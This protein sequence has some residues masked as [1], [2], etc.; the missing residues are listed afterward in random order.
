[1]PSGKKRKDIKFLLTREKKGVE[2]IDIKK[3]N[4]NYFLITF[5]EIEDLKSSNE[6][7]QV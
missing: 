7:N 5:I 6:T 1:M 4:L 3:S 2:L